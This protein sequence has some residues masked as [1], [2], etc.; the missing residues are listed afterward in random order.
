MAHR[1]AKRDSSV[2]FDAYQRDTRHVL[3]T[4]RAHSGARNTTNVQT[5]SDS[6]VSLF[7]SV[8]QQYDLDGSQGKRRRKLVAVRMCK[9]RVS[10]MY[11]YSYKSDNRDVPTGHLRQT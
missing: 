4:V 11:L 2:I 6:D 3:V 8:S 1:C 10:H 7:I 9:M 5:V